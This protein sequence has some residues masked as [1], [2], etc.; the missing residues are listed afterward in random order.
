MLTENDDGGTNAAGERRDAATGT[1]IR[2]AP[3]LH[4]VERRLAESWPPNQWQDTNVILA[5]S[6]GVDSVAL[7]RGIQSVKERFG[8]SGRLYVAH[9]NHGLRGEA[10]SADAAWVAE[11]C[12]RRGLEAVMGTADVAAAVAELGDGWEAA[13]RKLRYDFLGRAAERIG[14]RWVVTAHTADDQVET[15]LQRIVRGTGLGGL[16]GMRSH[17]PLSGGITLVRPMLNLWKRDLE[18]YLKNLG[19]DFRSDSSNDDFRFTR[20]RVRQQLLPLLRESFNEDVD[21]A[22]LRLAIQAQDAQ[23]FIERLAASLAEEC[24]STAHL[25]DGERSATQLRIN[26]ELLFGEP[27][28]VVREVCRKAWRE[29][30]WPEQSM[31]HSDWQ[32]LA[33]MAT[34]TDGLATANLPGNV[35]VRREQSL[36]ILQRRDLP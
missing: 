32:L 24:T 9:L 34:A 5:I 8:G 22:I 14:A 2:S 19:Q 26:C 36:L 3:A 10:S 11:T 1:V 15:V 16:T 7:L 31:R 17:R 35:L 23:L 6:G 28:V 30:S 18:E 4:E 13:A 25:E 33:R 21:G 12:R 27:E 29:L 20:N